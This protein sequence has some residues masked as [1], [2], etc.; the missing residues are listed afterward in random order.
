MNLEQFMFDHWMSLDPLID[1]VVAFIPEREFYNNH[2]NDP[3]LRRMR[4]DLDGLIYRRHRQPDNK[5]IQRL[6]HEKVLHY[7]QALKDIAETGRENYR[8]KLLTYSHSKK[9]TVLMELIRTYRLLKYL[10][11][12]V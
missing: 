8:K 1:Q 7:N 11:K 10:D 4:R 9:I 5:E 3:V 6:Y 2:L 12:E